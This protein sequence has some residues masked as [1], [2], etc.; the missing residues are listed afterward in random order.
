[1]ASKVPF[2]FKE[3]CSATNQ[4]NT[5]VN[6]MGVV[7]AVQRPRESRGTDWVC[8]FSISDPSYDESEEGLLVRFFRPMKTELPKI[9]GTGDVVVLR[10]I[11]I[12]EWSGR[13]LAMSGKSTS[14]AVFTSSSIPEKAPPRFKLAFEK[15]PGA[16]AP[17]PN[18]MEYAIFLCNSRDRTTFREISEPSPASA[19]VL[20]LQSNSS[21]QTSRSRLSRDR[22][23][24]IQDV[25]VNN[26]YELVGKV[27]KIYPSDCNVQLY[28]T[29]YTSHPQLFN[30]AYGYSEAPD[31]SSREGD[32]FGYTPQ[33]STNG[34]WPGPFGCRT[35]SLTLWPDHSYF[36]QNNVKQNDFVSLR[37][38]LIRKG[39]DGKNV[40]GSMH[41]ETKYP[42]QVN[43]SI[44]K[45]DGDDHRVK[46]IIRR[47]KIYSQE[48]KD[49]KQRFISEARGQKRKLGDGGKQLSKAQ[50]R[51][52]KRQQKE[53]SLRPQS[54]E[55]GIERPDENDPENTAIQPNTSKQNFNKHSKNPLTF[56][57]VLGRKGPLANL[58]TASSLLS[59]LDSHSP[60]LF[61][62]LL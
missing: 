54:K 60:A 20:P 14:W 6:L 15:E 31:V 28:I 46:D 41:T 51:K 48:F 36:A 8:T 19:D 4:T 34:N 57:F 5:P 11:K 56:I 35:L 50:V 9:Q 12:N 39:K 23:S 22:F 40:E 42:G 27:V 62:T 44:L 47:K 24:L 7:T 16:P 53:Q 59:Y 30:Y 29:D 38:V 21:I 32:E 18:E 61:H 49:Q 33:G 37:N 52:Q 2:G 45:D 17:M 1:M 43:I 26:Y 25:Q 58:E 3:L 10:N 13:M 55:Q